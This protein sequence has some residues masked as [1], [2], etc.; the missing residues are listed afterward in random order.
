MK[1]L[2]YKI[3]NFIERIS[4]VEDPVEAAKSMVGSIQQIVGIRDVFGDNKRCKM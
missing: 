2:K 1:A 3:Y 4:Y